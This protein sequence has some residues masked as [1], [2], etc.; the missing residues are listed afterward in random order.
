MDILSAGQRVQY[1]D[2]YK[3]QVGNLCKSILLHN[4]ILVVGPWWF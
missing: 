2:S 1:K 4:I 3:L